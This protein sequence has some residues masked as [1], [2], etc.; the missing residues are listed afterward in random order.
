[1]IPCP[2]CANL[3]KPTREHVIPEWYTTAVG[4]EDLETFNALRPTKHLKGDLEIKD[5]CEICNNGVLSD[6]DAYG[7]ELYLRYWER[8][9]YRN[10][11]I[12]F[13]YDYQRLVRWLLKLCFNSARAHNADVTILSKYARYILG[14]ES[15]PA[16]I[17]VY[18][19]LV[20]PTDGSTDPPTAAYRIFGS[21]NYI[22][23]PLWF[24]LV[25]MRPDATLYSDVVQR[26]VYINSFCFSLFIC[27]PGRERHESEVETLQASL[28]KITPSAVP[29]SPS[30]RVILT[31][32]SVHT[33][34]TYIGLIAN[35]PAR[36]LGGP[37]SEYD[38]FAAGMSELIDGKIQAIGYEVSRQEIETG[39]ITFAANRLR[40]L[41]ATKESAIAAM[42]RVA[43]AVDGYNDDSRE[44]WDISEARNWVIRLFRECPFIAFLAIPSS[45]TLELLAICYCKEDEALM[46]QPSK[47]K[48]FIELSFGALNELTQRYAISIEINKRITHH[49]FS[50]FQKLTLPPPTDA[51]HSAYS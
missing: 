18:I 2:Y 6:L 40:E 25:Q 30:G 47:V 32:G 17:V 15:E 28:L 48:E 34:D 26:Q 51:D 19:N 22:I 21:P 7:K 16:P 9:A 3:C 33:A 38:D 12:E 36:Y 42:E 5:V 50:V 45:N 24:R 13:E 23:E 11:T 35:Y 49:V 41:V 31:G 27:D 8:S 37:Y 10:E 46:F 20:V 29:L 14:L 39:N 44:V 43:I 4:K 1:M